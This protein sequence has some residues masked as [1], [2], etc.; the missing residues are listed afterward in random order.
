MVL[1]PAQVKVAVWPS[2]ATAQTDAVVAL[3]L[4]ET[5]CTPDPSLPMI[6]HESVN[7]PTV[8]GAKITVRVR[9]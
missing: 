1:P 8:V 2:A 4:K 7:V 9:A 5:V 3:P 6:I